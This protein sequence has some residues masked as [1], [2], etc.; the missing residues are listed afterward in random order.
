[1]ALNYKR[2]AEF[3]L[4]IL[5]VKCNYAHTIAH[6]AFLS[7]VL[8]VV[9]I[10]SNGDDP[11]KVGLCAQPVLYSRFV[12]AKVFMIVL[13]ASSHSEEPLKFVS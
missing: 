4:K 12:H 1:M 2:P 11:Q 5:P 7:P 13:A 3:R 10:R 9:Q 8:R 6:V